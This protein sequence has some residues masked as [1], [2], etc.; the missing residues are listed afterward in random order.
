MSIEF[1]RP[2][3]QRPLDV[4]GFEVDSATRELAARFY[5]FAAAG[6]GRGH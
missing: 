1:Y 4:D 2:E 5:D 3:S 6:G